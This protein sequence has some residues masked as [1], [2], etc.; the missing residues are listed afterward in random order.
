MEVLLIDMGALAMFLAYMAI[1]Y[2]RGVSHEAQRPGNNSP[3]RVTAWGNFLARNF[4][5]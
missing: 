2:W 4:H 1:L 3:V 5:E